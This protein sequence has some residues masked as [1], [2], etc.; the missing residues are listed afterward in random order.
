MFPELLGI[1]LQTE[2]KKGLE[3]P[4]VSLQ[5][6]LSVKRDE[7]THKQTEKFANFPPV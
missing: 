1:I 7:K 3:C 2:H 4:S 5:G 6:N